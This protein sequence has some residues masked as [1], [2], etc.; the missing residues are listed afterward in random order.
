MQHTA[1]LGNKGGIAQFP[2]RQ[3]VLLVRRTGHI[4]MAAYLRV[5]V[6][7]CVCVCGKERELIMLYLPALPVRAN[8]P[9]R[10]MGKRL[11][12]TRLLVDDEVEQPINFKHR[13]W[14]FPIT[15]KVR[16]ANC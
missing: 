4:V 2:Y 10:N 15:A 6:C 3:K 1:V 11:W 12:D 16:A 8:A 5:C 14:A 9:D 13:K 7:V